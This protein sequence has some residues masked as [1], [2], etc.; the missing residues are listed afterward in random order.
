MERFT[1]VEQYYR[2]SL[3]RFNQAELKQTAKGLAF[4][5]IYAIYEFT[6]RQATSIA[7][8][9]IATHGHTYSELK[10]PV[11]A[12]F[13]DPQIRSLRD[14]S[15]KEIWSRR[16]EMLKQAVSN[17]AIDVVDTIPHDGSHFRHSQTELILKML[18][19][20]RTLTVRQRHRYEIDE[21]VQNRNS[22]SHG[23]ETAIEVGRRYSSS[24]ISRKIRIMKTVCLRLIEIVS[25][26]CSEPSN[27]TR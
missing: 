7:I 22:I 25:K 3:K 5:Q 2:N 12:V 23:D 27:H 21:I 15:E 13:L 8:K 18:G 14:C 24:D 17:K 11:L 19:V 1:V 20:K 10:F 16:F 9:E 26:H 4:I 6:V